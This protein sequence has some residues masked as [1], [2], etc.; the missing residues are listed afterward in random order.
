MK[1]KYLPLLR[2][3]NEQASWTASTQ[4][5]EKFSL[6]KRTIKSYISE[7]QEN[8]P[9]LILSSNKGYRVDPV[10]LANVQENIQVGTPETPPERM[11]YL[12]LKLTATEEA[13]A[14][15]DLV[16][17]LFVSESTLMK[18]LKKIKRKCAEH[19]LVLIQDSDSIQLRGSEKAKRQLIHA[20]LLS[21]LEQNFVDITKLQES[22]TDFDLDYIKEIVAEIFSNYDFFTNDYALI[23]IIIHL[24]IAIDRMKSNFQFSEADNQTPSSIPP[25]INQIAADIAGKIADHYNLHFPKEEVRDLALLISA[26][27]TNVNFTQI[28]AEELREVADQ[29]C[30][31]LVKK[32][33][34]KVSELYFIDNNEPEFLI[35]FTLHIKNLLFRLDNDYSC[36]N[37]MTETLKKECPLIYDCAVQVSHVIQRE[38][39][40]TITEDEIA[41]I[42]FHLGYALEVQKQRTSKINCALLVPLYYNMN[43]QVMKKLQNHFGD[44]LDITNILTNEKELQHIQTE[45]II[46][47]IKLKQITT[48]PYVVINPFFTLEDRQQVS[49]KIFELKEIKRK[50][51][52]SKNLL[53]VVDKKHFIYREKKMASE[54][55]LQEL[56]T[57]MEQ[58]GFVGNDF[59]TQLMEREKLSSTAFGPVALPHTLT[60]D[61]KKT[62]IFIVAAPKGIQWGSQVVTLVFL[63]SINY[64]NRHLFRELFDDLALICT[65]EQNVHR[66]SQS[67]SFDTFIEN[68]MQCFTTIR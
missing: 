21:E 10:R 29:R 57:Q 20:I 48:T 5:A 66:L 23:N 54:P 53:S 30:L 2:Y 59:F 44:D 41:Y 24:A 37:P 35:R 49:E 12:L 7:I 22:F 31:D 65:D 40:H 45:F 8:E 47:A 67:K 1:V 3:L 42:A 26:N 16:E 33:L 68:L 55:L 18:D 36:R 25:L 4:L 51:Q 28:S 17:E 63:L 14:I 61:A 9:G 11:A 50:E 52:F 27:G 64:H 38:L 15:Y 6:S 43:I 60:M 56:C 19:S 62:G 34:S 46:S 39:A 32:I 58:D 13:L